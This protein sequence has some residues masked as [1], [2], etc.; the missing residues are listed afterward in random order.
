[1]RLQDL[2]DDLDGGESSFNEMGCTLTKA[3]MFIVARRVADLY[4]EC[5]PC[6]GT[7]HLFGLGDPSLVC[8][9]GCG[10]TGLIPT[11][12][13]AEALTPTGHNGHAWLSSTLRDLAR[14]L[15][16]EEEQ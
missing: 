8:M 16:G 5:D 6:K 7:G 11:D 10:G 15:F 12:R 14:Y 1:M 9:M 4:Q 13:A 3:P 2:K